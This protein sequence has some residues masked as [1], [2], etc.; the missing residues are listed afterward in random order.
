MQSTLGAQ[1][2]RHCF[3]FYIYVYFTSSTRLRLSHAARASPRAD[4]LCFAS[5]QWAIRGHSYR[6]SAASAVSTALVRRCSVGA[7]GRL[8]EGAGT[9]TEATMWYQSLALQV[10]PLARAR[11][12]SASKVRRG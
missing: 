2:A 1:L 3:V 5:A 6:L 11:R 8:G 7:S 12:S 9:T 10:E 4:R